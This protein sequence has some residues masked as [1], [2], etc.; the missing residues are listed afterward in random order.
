[1]KSFEGRVPRSYKVAFILSQRPEVRAREVVARAR[2]QGIYLTEQRVYAVRFAAKNQG[3]PRLSK[4]AFVLSQPDEL[5]AR[6]VL[7]LGRAAGVELREAQVHN[8]R[9]A[10]R[11]KRKLAGHSR[12]ATE[13]PRNAPVEQGAGSPK[14][15]KRGR[16]RQVEGTLAAE[17]QLR[18]WIGELGLSRTRELLLEIERTFAAS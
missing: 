18:R 5:S 12:V 11:R 13:T 4:A 2:E 16:P 7:A 9:W 6:E 3:P 8:I 1:M 17:P 15:T 14:L 10:A